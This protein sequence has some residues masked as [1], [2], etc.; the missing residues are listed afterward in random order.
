MSWNGTFVVLPIE[1]GSKGITLPEWLNLLTLSL[2]PIIV[3]IVA[4]A[5]RPSYLCQS[6]P[7]WH[8]LICNFNPTSILWRYAA[9]TDRRIRSPTWTVV[10][11]AA[12]NAVF[13]TSN[14]WNGADSMVS[15]SL[16]FATRLPEK[17][18]VQFFSIEMG[19]TVITVVQGIQ[20]FAS[21]LGLFTHQGDYT[22][23]DAVSGLFIPIALCGL[24]RLFPARWLT[25]DFYYTVIADDQMST[26][27]GTSGTS[28]VDTDGRRHSVDSLI[29][30][31]NEGFSPPGYGLFSPAL[32]WRRQSLSTIFK[33]FYIIP[34]LCAWTLAFLFIT[35]W[36]STVNTPGVWS[37]TSYMLGL[38]YMFILTPTILIY[39]SYW[40]RGYTTTT[41]IPCI[42]SSW[43]KVYSLLV[44]IWM[45]LLVCLSSIETRKSVCG[46]YTAMP[47]RYGDPCATGNI[48]VV[49]VGWD[50]G[51]TFGLAQNLTIEGQFVVANF[52]G[53]CMGAFSFMESGKNATLLELGASATGRKRNK[54][55]ELM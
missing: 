22:T 12:S 6:R 29:Q 48:K 44:L 36:V 14:G 46:K 10:D 34:F 49:H 28:F 55:K 52:T 18:R 37:L 53:T 42:S 4:G 3:H 23:I 26:Y 2:A 19:K 5:P 40:I 13:W 54:Q 51:N 11:V 33:V 50:V 32:S 31:P 7:K 39:V 15:A 27:P 43:Y 47:E 35:P 17:P 16:P 25:D 21:L 45:L 20:A 24:L 8:D 41:L 9:I 38:F 1:W 30:A